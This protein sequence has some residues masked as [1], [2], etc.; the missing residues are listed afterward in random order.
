MLFQVT[1]KVCSATKGLET[2]FI[3]AG[4]TAVRFMITSRVGSGNRRDSS[5]HLGDLRARDRR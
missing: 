2:A 5:G 1:A 3:S 4:G